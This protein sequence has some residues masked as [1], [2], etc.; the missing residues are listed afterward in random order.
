M[1]TYVQGD[2]M[3]KDKNRDKYSYIYFLVITAVLMLLALM[4]TVDGGIN[5]LY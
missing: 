1:V 4:A 5:E 3:L 2:G